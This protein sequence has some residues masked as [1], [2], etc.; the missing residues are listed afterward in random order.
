MLPPK[1][2]KRLLP[3]VE[4][5]SGLGILLLWKNCMPNW[6]LKI[7]RKA[8]KALAKLPDKDQ[9]LILAA[10]DEMVIDSFSGDIKRLR[11]YGAS[12]RRRVGNYRIF[13]DVYPDQLMVDVVDIN[14]RT[15]KTY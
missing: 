7:A 2:K 15:S 4:P 1:R 10:F 11:S 3:A 14:R 5:K 12:W 13:F 9:R 6:T 8:E